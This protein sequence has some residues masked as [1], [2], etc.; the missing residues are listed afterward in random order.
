MLD[1]VT[2]RARST[3]FVGRDAEIAALR[4]ALKRARTGEP[5]MLLVG[6]EAGVGKTRLIEE[7]AKQAGAARFLT[8]QCLELGEEGLP[9]APFAGIV[10]ELVRTDGIAVLDGHEAEFA[11][12]LPEL[13]A[14]SH[15]A[16][17]SLLFDRVAA[18][19]A[20]LAAE[21]PLV[22]V[23]EDLHWA[24][25]STRD[26]IEFLVRAARTARVLMVCTYRTDELHR[27]HP[28]RAF[29]A[30][31]DRARGVER[32]D[33][34][35]LDRD[36]TA[37][38]LTSI[39]GGEPGQRAIDKV[40]QRAQGN[41]F[42]V[43]ELAASGD[44]AACADI[45]ESLRDLLLARVDRLPESAQPVLRIAAAGGN[46]IGHELLATVAGLPEAALDAALRTAV[47]A[48]LLVADS[49]G[50]YE[51]RHALVR[52]AVHDDL[53]P[54]EHARLHARYAAAIEA[55]PTLV[56]SGR[57]PAE[58]AHHWYAAHDHPRAL[59]TCHAAAVAAG[60]RYAHAEQARLLERVLDLWEQ[61]PDAADRLGIDHLTLLEETMVATYTAGD[62]KRALSLNRAALH[63]VDRAAEPLRS[64]RLLTRRG[65][66]L[67]TLGK[68]DG[69]AELREAV[70]LAE[71]APDDSARAM[72]LA[73]IAYQVSRSDRD[74][75]ARIAALARASAMS[76][77]DE[78]AAVYATLTLGRACS[79]LDALDVGLPELRKAEARARS[80]G[81]IEGLVHARVN[82]S[83]ALFEIGD[84]A[85]SAEAA[86]LGTKDA[87]KVGVDRS[88]G[89]FV[90]SNHAEALMALGR[91]DEADAICAVSAR[92]DPP[93]HLGLHWLQLRAGLRLA[94][95]DASAQEL[96]SRALAFLARPYV[97]AQHRLPL[98]TLKIEAALAGG[99]PAAA[100]EA[101]RGALRGGAGRDG[102]G[103]TGSPVGGRGSA[104][105]AGQVVGG[106]GS[107]DD[108]G[109][110]DGTAWEADL[111]ANPRYTWPLLA[112]ATRAA[113]AAGDE[114]LG[115]AVGGLA[116]RLE[117]QYPADR[118]F[119]AEI[120][121]GLTGAGWAGFAL[122]TPG[123]SGPAG[124]VPVQGRR[125]LSECG[126]D[127]QTGAVG[128]AT[129][130]KAGAGPTGSGD[131]AA[132]P[133]DGA[134][135][136]GD[137]AVRPGDG[138]V[139]PGDGAVRPGDGAVRPGDGAVRPGDGAARP[140]GRAAEVVRERWA[141]AVEAWRVDG[142]PYALARALVG[143][144]EAAAAAGD[145][146]AAGEAL[147]E[148]GAIAADLD[149][150]P[151][152]DEVAR[153]AR[154]VG[155]RGAVGAGPDVLTA[156]EREVLRLV[157][158]G[159]SNSRIAAELYLSPK[160]VSVHVS[161]IIAKLEVTNRIEAAAVA[162]RLGLLGADM[163]AGGQTTASGH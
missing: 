8:G 60:E 14:A 149:A 47:T 33:L 65:K 75:G 118:A 125:G 48:Q 148:A 43:E 53:L 69:R 64:A 153:L 126:A 108:A 81:D 31:L 26:L 120:L 70:A 42:F 37:E 16:A 97:S 17:R 155:L 147:E 90:R 66:L 96:V 73:D 1:A 92:F 85:A 146:A 160:T 83:D 23:L 39:F 22:V 106:R 98:L 163:I 9:Y 100:A 114:A 132:R 91:W 52:E 158:V 63:A 130:D 162:H 135:R 129:P 36:G 103:V 61:V 119:A 123:R 15:D 124:A 107:V 19:L 104:V 59:T 131:G 5:A 67:G 68:S 116:G 151:L 58:I 4:E 50:G 109:R 76:L 79:R 34:G 95:G 159:H 157:A 40:H 49:D 44:P 71:A 121:A 7:F 138:A 89:A 56:G 94:R 32:L 142:R 86:A 102:G 45:P 38:I 110:D 78:G 152:R 54:G 21:Q 2:V 11:R 27:G 140:G 10:R 128:S 115:V 41:P 145:R 93:G 62:Y 13:G 139:R 18:L 88:S 150:R 30:E 105:A 24:D 82:I 80:M 46:R 134:V 136:P 51:F 87:G 154:R 3:A 6:G 35:R 12:L 122:L 127:G 161:R 84:Y 143:L 77:G 29:V 144:A 112:A 25:R 111:V 133:G 137:G 28:L 99:D 74:E 141:A 20:R 72:L 57:A 156:R 113:V 101:G 55:D 117:C